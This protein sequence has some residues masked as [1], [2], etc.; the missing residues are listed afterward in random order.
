MLLTQFLPFVLVLATAC[1]GSG[2]EEFPNGTIN[3]AADFFTFP[4]IEAMAE[5]SGLVI[6]GTVAEVDDGQFV[7]APGTE[8]F[9]GTQY[10]AVVVDIEET[11]LGA[12]DSEQVEIRW[13]G[14]EVEA[15]GSEGPQQILDGEFP[16]VVGERYVWFLKTD[17]PDGQIAR[18]GGEAQLMIDQ[19]D[20]LTP[21]NALY[22]G[23]AQ[24][25]EGMTLDGLRETLA[26]DKS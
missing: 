20:I 1:A 18:T 26:S 15:D 16:P 25:L 19:E 5:A 23:A 2:G 13:F 4:S 10:L 21:T 8:D 11:L 3:V 17:L 9:R 22:S 14:Y 6:V 7:P 24:E 12:H